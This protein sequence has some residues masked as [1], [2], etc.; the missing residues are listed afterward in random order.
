MTQAGDSKVEE[1]AEALSGVFGV[2]LVDADPKAQMIY[3]QQAKK[4]IKDMDYAPEPGLIKFS[5]D[6]IVPLTPPTGEIFSLK[7]KFT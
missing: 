1:M 5:E 3:R 4:I 7:P 6:D 2:K